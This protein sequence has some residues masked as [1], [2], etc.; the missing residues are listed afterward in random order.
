MS[1]FKKTKK[2]QKGVSLY[3]ITIMISILMGFSLSVSGIIVGSTKITGGTGDSV[4]AF[5]CADTAVEKA[6]YDVSLNNCVYYTPVAGTVNGD[7]AYSFTYTILSADC[8]QTG[9]TI[10]AMGAYNQATRKIQINY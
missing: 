2:N 1:I 7:S 4:K 6:L 8:T 5:H 10:D 3:M 9:T